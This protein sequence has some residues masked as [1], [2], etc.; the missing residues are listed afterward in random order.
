[1]SLFPK[2]R[3]NRG[4]YPRPTHL[5]LFATAFAGSGAMAFQGLPPRVLGHL[6]VKLSGQRVY[7]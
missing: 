4:V 3:T 1:M 2:A 7:G 6:R 5:L